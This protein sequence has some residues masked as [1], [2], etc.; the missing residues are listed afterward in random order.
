MR[1]SSN[2][3]RTFSM[4]RCLLLIKRKKFNKTNWQKQCR[5]SENRS[6]TIDCRARVIHFQKINIKFSKREPLQ[7]NLIPKKTVNELQPLLQDKI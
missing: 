6:S 2:P 1:Y 3:I 4:N 5:S 7:K